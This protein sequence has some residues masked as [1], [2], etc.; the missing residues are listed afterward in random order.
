MSARLCKVFVNLRL[1]E[2]SLDEVKSYFEQLGSVTAVRAKGPTNTVVVTYA[3]PEHAQRAC[4]ELDKVTMHTLSMGANDL[5]VSPF[6]ESASV[7][8]P[9]G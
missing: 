9:S 7:L 1:S 2:T 4:L 6:A 5:R 3:Q 8:A